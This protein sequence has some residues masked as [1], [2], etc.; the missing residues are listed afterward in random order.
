MAK[1]HGEEHGAIGGEDMAFVGVCAFAV[2][3]VKIQEDF[4]IL[5]YFCKISGGRKEI[6]VGY[7]STHVQITQ[8]R[9]KN[10]QV[11]AKGRILL[12]ICALLVT[13]K[14]SAIDA[15]ITYAAFNRPS[16]EP[17]VELYALLIGGS[18]KY[19]QNAN[20]KYQANCLVDVRFA[21]GGKAVHRDLFRVVGQELASPNKA[22]D[23][24]EQR[25]YALANGMYDL[26]LEIK[27]LA[28]S[29]NTFFYTTFVEVRF[30]TGVP[31]LSDIEIIS[32]HQRAKEEDQF[33]KNGLQIFP[34]GIHYYPNRD[35]MLKFY[36][37][38][39]FPTKADSFYLVKYFITNNKVSK[40]PFNKLSVTK[41]AQ[42]KPASPLIGAINIKSI[43]SGNYYF[44]LELTDKQG[45]VLASKMAA[46]QRNNPISVP[47]LEN[48]V[49]LQQLDKWVDTLSDAQV[50]RACAALI[51]SVEKNYE[52][53]LKDVLNGRKV[54]EQK[55]FLQTYWK[56]KDP[57]YFL[58]AYQEY[59]E[60]VAIAEEKFGYNLRKGYTTDRGYVFLRHGQP[61]YVNR[62]EDDFN[63]YPYEVWEY[64]DFKPNQQNAVFVF[65]CKS[66]IPNDYRQI[67]SSA[68]G[69]TSNPN[70]RNDILRVQ[71]S[72]TNP[73]SPNSNLNDTWND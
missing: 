62:R 44:Y 49:D 38:A 1:R 27:D 6:K 37:E 9:Y 39:Y 41:K 10:T 22:P 29:T 17:Y 8:M 32:G 5:A 72:G 71:G 66:M 20:G 51:P 65:A 34:K 36:A 25:R 63:R 26:T 7:Q 11:P 43:P 45:N 19:N 42:P 73:A 57:L 59:M 35:S 23:L 14:L 30:E 60:L 58:E 61:N 56:N 4:G 64:H 18:L 46:I 54:R 70:W 28:D 68:Q 31:S 55:Q 48:F 16:G 67:H 33:S 53:A 15:S 3:L 52:R 24:I 50:E 13:A 12:A 47:K 21:Q 40:E 69:E 2:N